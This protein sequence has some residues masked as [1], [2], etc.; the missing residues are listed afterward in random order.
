[1]LRKKRAQR[2]CILLGLTTNVI[3]HVAIAATSGGL[4]GH[5]Q[6]NGDM[7]PVANARLEIRETGASTSS[8]SDGE[9]LFKDLPPGDYTLVITVGKQTPVEQAVHVDTGSV[10]TRAITIGIE[11]KGVA[12]SEKSE[13]AEGAKDANVAALAN[14]T[15]N[16]RRSAV[17]VS[18]ARQEVA[19]NMINILPAEEIR[20]L[21][22]VN[23]GEAVRRI[24]GVSLESDT[25]EGRFV[26]IRGLDAD[27]TGTTFGGVR[28]PPTN[29]ASPF[30]GGR[31][32]AFDS[33]PAGIIGSIV[34]TKTNK[35]EQDAEALGGTVE[36]TP[37]TVPLSGKPFLE[38]KIGTGIEPLRNT[39]IK[40]LGVTFG[41]RFGAREN[42][43]K[44]G[45]FVAYSDRPF[46][47][48]GT[49][50]YYE[51]RRGV[52]DLEASYVDGQPAIPD[53]AYGSLEQRY[54]N[55]H[56]KRHGYGGELAYE[57]DAANKWY[58][59]YYD[60]GYTETVSRNRL[61]LNF[62]GSPTT[63]ADGS[64]TEQGV[65]FDKTLRDEK[66]TIDTKIFTI[67][68][69]HDLGGA[70]LDYQLAH[71]IG[72]YDKQHDYNSDFSN[73]GASTVTYN[74][75]AS[76]NFP[77]YN[78]VGGTNPL[79]TSGYTLTGFNNG[80]Q[81]NTTREWSAATN[82]AIATHFTAAEDEELKFGASVRLRKNT[83]A[84]GAFT[85]SAV[86][87]IP[88]SQATSGSGVTYYDNHYQNGPQVNQELMRSTYQNGTGFV[89]NTAA[90]AATAARGAADNKEN[91]YALYGQYQFGFGRLGVL[92]GLRAE[93]T[94][95]QFNGNAVSTQV[96]SAN[97]T[98]YPSQRISADSKYTNYFPSLQAR[99]EFAPSLIGR[100]IYS[101]TI[102]RPGFNQTSAAMNINPGGDFVSQGNPGL[103]ATTSNNIDLS[104]EH[105]LAQG[106]I[107][108][109][110]IF[111]KALSNYIVSKVSTQTFP[112]NGLFAGFTGPAKVFTYDNVSS[113]RVFGYELNYEQRYRSLPGLL[114]GFGTSFNWT[115]V[116]SRLEI[117]P[118]EFAALPS[119]SKNTGNAA[120]FY[121]RNGLDMRLAAYYVSRNLFGVGSSAAT[122]IYSEPRFSLDFGASYALKSN[123]SIY[124][125]VKNLTNTAMK[126]TEGTDNRPIQRETYGKTIQVGLMANY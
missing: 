4:Q 83:Q 5:L 61:L 50:S 88:L 44:D 105:Y 55:Y 58:V 56:R 99:Y 107:A 104:I 108:S 68:G 101:S 71:T 27:L 124:L 87:A 31:A 67:G 84:I 53:K 121:E 115:W 90:D 120:L 106:G 86:P 40:D 25:G 13:K 123:I 109:F 12:E 62:P 81:Q 82:L 28:L 79:D 15:I 74:N 10:T 118:G 21:P 49:L 95:A 103:K 45:Q 16:S 93:L 64:F 24:P 116:H 111:N 35:P 100:A 80:T 65:T 91:V 112:N 98:T 51:D 125:N 114:S 66:E 70:K 6:S 8:A 57:P 59:R 19:P 29:T 26:N 76:P 14:V 20:K 69:K 126:F 46:S 34:V 33:I 52:D 9:F 11:S 113:A 54:Y 3:A 1:M 17:T 18:R 36:I 63:N 96:D 73:S 32:V 77:T 119:T 78:I 23:A 117:R 37:K 92:T 48:I 102:S 2:V 41:G 30:G 97:N 94:R 122:D 43:P 110:G 47:F 85:Y 72:S 75:T 42:A 89:Q 60:A 38:A 39:G 22:D 7:R